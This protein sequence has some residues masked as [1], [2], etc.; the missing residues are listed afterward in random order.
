MS[1]DSCFHDSQ[2][3][4]LKCTDYL[5]GWGCASRPGCI[6]IRAFSRL[7]DFKERKEKWAKRIRKKDLKSKGEV[8]SISIPSI[9]SYL[10]E[11]IEYKVYYKIFYFKFFAPGDII[12]FIF[13]E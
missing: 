12:F 13:H 6:L 11:N 10:I 3:W 9:I 1:T 8:Y 4:S 5:G 2:L 7:L